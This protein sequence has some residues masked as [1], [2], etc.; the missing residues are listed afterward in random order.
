MIQGRH[1]FH[2]PLGD[3]STNATEH[4]FHHLQWFYRKVHECLGEVS[5][6]HLV[7]QLSVTVDVYTR[8]SHESPG[9]LA[10][11]SSHFLDSSFEPTLSSKHSDNEKGNRK[12]ANRKQLFNVS[13]PSLHAESRAVP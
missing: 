1:T 13:F 2:T 12:I 3:Q 5:A 10:S 7:T 11:F 9:S 8:L 4:N 6:R